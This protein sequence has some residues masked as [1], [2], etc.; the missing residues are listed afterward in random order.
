MEVK[1]SYTIKH[2]DSVCCPFKWL[3]ENCLLQNLM[4]PAPCRSLKACVIVQNQTHT[5][6]WHDLSSSYSNHWHMD[7]SRRTLMVILREPLSLRSQDLHAPRNTSG[8]NGES[9]RKH[10][11]LAALWGPNF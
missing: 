1:D 5:V 9:N 7:T 6:F 8:P 2:M 4:E 3:S 10:V 11:Q